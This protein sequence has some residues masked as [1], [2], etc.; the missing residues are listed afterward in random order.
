[1]SLAAL[2]AASLALDAA[3]PIVLLPFSCDYLDYF[4]VVE[5][6]SV[7]FIGEGRW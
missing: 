3:C 2:V 4:V 5:V 7:M 1:M 6:M